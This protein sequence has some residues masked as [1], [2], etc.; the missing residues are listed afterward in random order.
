[1][2][3]LTADPGRGI[4]HSETDLE[5]RVLEAVR[6]FFARCYRAQVILQEALQRALPADCH[7]WA[8]AEFRTRRGADRVHADTTGHTS[9]YLLYSPEAWANGPALLTC[10]GMAGLE[11]A[12]WARFLAI[13]RS[14][15]L[16]RVLSSHEMWFIMA[17][18]DTLPPP[19]ARPIDF[20]QILKDYTRQIHL[21]GAA[22]RD[23]ASEAWRPVPLPL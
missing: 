8:N 17:N 5:K 13:N 7:A 22:T 14:D 10:F 6:P 12:V 1:L 18:W 23:V 3:A 19:P 2:V 9:G 20:D 21:L 16:D 4:R 15:L 11:S